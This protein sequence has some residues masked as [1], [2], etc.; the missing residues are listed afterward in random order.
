RFCL[1]SGDL[2]AR[3][4]SCRCSELVMNPPGVSITIDAYTPMGYLSIHAERDES[5]LSEAVGPD[6]GASA[7]SRAYGR[8]G[9]LLH[10][11]R[12]ADISRQGCTAAGR[13]GNSP[14]PR[15]SLR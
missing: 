2:G 12:D 11:Y 7:R 13:G 1:R 15:R 4:R 3:A 14:G 8:A 9:P 10:R 6:R 5:I